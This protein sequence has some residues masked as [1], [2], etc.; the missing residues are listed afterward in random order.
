LQCGFI[1]SAPEPLLYTNIQPFFVA[2]AGGSPCYRQQPFAIKPFVGAGG[3]S[4]SSSQANALTDT[5]AAKSLA[6]A[7]S[8]AF[9][10]E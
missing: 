7:M 9:G 5:G 8:Q 4:S 1:A 2:Q 10:G 3:P 6:E